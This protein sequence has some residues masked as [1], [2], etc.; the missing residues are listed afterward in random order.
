M[1]FLFC[2]S[3]QWA[4]DVGLSHCWRSVTSLRWCLLGSGT[5][6]TVT[7]SFFGINKYLGV[8]VGFVDYANVSLCFPHYL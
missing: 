6:C 5:H 1:L 7:D 2:A 8:G 4:L 3:C